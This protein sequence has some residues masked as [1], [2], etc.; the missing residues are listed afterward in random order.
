MF[1]ILVDQD[2][3]LADFEQG[4]LAAWQREFPSELFVPIE[5]RKSRFVDQDYPL[6]L[7]P[8]VQW[9]IHQPG[10]YFNLPPTEG[11]IEAVF[12]IQESKEYDLWICTTPLP[13]YNPC[14]LEKYRW[15]EKHLGRDFTRKMI[16][17][18]DKT[19]IR[20][21][22]LVDDN[23]QIEG[24]LPPEWEHLVFDYPQNRNVAQEKRRISW[25][26]WREV[27]CSHT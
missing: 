16:S 3:P 23:P 5:E 26:N 7:R 15:V 1:I 17:T 22:F 24:S 11:A 27:L 20:G 13:A 25:A 2:G 6:H 14:V 12:Q 8:K 9:L 4:F 10:F 19:L 21:H 18:R